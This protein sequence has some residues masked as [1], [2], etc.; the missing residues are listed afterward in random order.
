MKPVNAGAVAAE[1]RRLAEALDKISDQSVPTVMVS[2]FAEEREEFLNVA[3]SLPRPIRKYRE[4][5]AY[6]NFI[7]GHGDPM[8]DPAWIRALI[9]ADKTCRIVKPARPAIYDC[10]P[11]L[12]LDEVEA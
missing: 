1:L 9:S 11:I 3:K 8:K 10:E 5:N 7:V 6:P 4:D 2:F 12:S